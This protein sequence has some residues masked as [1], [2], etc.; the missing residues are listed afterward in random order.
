MAFRRRESDQN[1][2]CGNLD[3]QWAIRFS[4][5]HRGKFFGGQVCACRSCRFHRDNSFSIYG[6]YSLMFCHIFLHKDRMGDYNRLCPIL[7]RRNTL[8]FFSFCMAGSPL[9]GN[10]FH[11]CVCDN[12]ECVHI[13]FHTE[14]LVYLSYIWLNVEFF[15]IDRWLKYLPASRVDICRY[16]IFEG[17]GGYSEVLFFSCKFIRRN[18]VRDRGHILGWGV[19]RSSNSI[20]AW[21]SCIRSCTVGI[22]S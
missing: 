16:D 12:S 7:F 10:F 5:F 14:M 2:S 8:S 22:S 11:I 4:I 20:W 13:S 19:Y 6:S 1:N 9:Y 17:R 18:G 15:H 3:L 21:V